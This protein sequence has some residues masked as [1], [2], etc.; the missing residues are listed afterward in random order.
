MSDTTRAG[1]IQRVG[2]TR[3]EHTPESPG[4]PEVF[5][6]GGAV[7]EFATDSG[8]PADRLLGLVVD[9]WPG[10]TAEQRLAILEIIA[11]GPES[12]PP[13]AGDG[14]GDGTAG[15]SRKTNFRRRA[16]GR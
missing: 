2:A 12:R 6:I 14:D 7:E 4:I 5:V 3:F 13:A 10:L 8:R 1:E 15:R 16:A 9:R 11:A